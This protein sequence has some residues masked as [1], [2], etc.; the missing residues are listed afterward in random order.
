ML[1]LFSLFHPL[2]FVDI[3]PLTKKLKE[4]GVFGVSS[5]EY[6]DYALKNR[7]EWEAKGEQVVAEMTEKVQRKYGIKV[8]NEII[9]TTST[10]GGVSSNL[11]PLNKEKQPSS[12]RL[13]TVV[14]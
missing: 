11:N 5:G 2:Q 14:E 4:C 1:C 10:E 12:V 8:G 9:K 7:K 6:L 3:I 13:G